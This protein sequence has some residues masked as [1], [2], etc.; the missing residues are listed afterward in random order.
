MNVNNVSSTLGCGNTVVNKT[1][2]LLLCDYILVERAENK[3]IN[4]ELY[5][6]VRGW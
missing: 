4:E 5:D 1:K 3:Q 2:F 6:S